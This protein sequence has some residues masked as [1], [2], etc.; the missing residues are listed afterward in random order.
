MN[1]TDGTLHHAAGTGKS[2]FAVAEGPAIDAQL[3]S[4]KGVAVAPDGSAYIADSS[5]HVIRRIDPVKGTISVIAGQPGKKGFAGDGGPPTEALLNN[6][7]GILVGPDGTIYIGDSD[8]NRI[9]R[10]T[11]H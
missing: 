1:T 6:P 10:I 11:S 8:N 9:R 2:G 7:H 5:N 3:A 4:P